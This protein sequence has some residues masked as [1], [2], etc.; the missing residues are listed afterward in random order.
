MDFELS[1][2][3]R[4]NTTLYFALGWFGCH[5]FFFSTEVNRVYELGVVIDSYGNIRKF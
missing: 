1:R 3:R 2:K 5:E 4:L